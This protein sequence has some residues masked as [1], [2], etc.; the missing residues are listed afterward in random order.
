MKDTFKNLEIRAKE[1]LDIDEVNNLRHEIDESE[2]SKV[3]TFS[4]WEILS[5]MVAKRI[6]AMILEARYN[7]TYRK[8]YHVEDGKTIVRAIGTVSGD[9][10]KGEYKYKGMTYGIDVPVNMLP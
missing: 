7:R 8:C 5:D 3:I 10:F 1:F 6:K 2:E 9:R 4:Q